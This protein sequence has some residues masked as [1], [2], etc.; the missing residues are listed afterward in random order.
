MFK[1]PLNFSNTIYLQLGVQAYTYIYIHNSVPPRPIRGQEQKGTKTFKHLK[2]LG[3]AYI[4]STSGQNNS[5]TLD[6][7]I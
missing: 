3:N 6:D 7:N 5:Y 4:I 2:C 1:S